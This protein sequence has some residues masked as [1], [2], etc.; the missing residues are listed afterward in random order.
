MV[1]E[2]HESVELRALRVELHH[3][4]EQVRVLLTESLRL[5]SG[6]T[7]HAEVGRLLTTLAHAGRLSVPEAPPVLVLGRWSDGARSGAALVLVVDGRAEVRRLR[8]AAI[9][10]LEAVISGKG[11]DAGEAS[12]W[13]DAFAPGMVAAAA[14]VGVEEPALISLVIGVR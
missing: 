8:A 14:D 7:E 12:M 5:A 11:T 10:E 2:Q 4:L 1:T 9:P 3:A 13:L 6:L